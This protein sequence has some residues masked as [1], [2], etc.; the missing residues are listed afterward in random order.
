[1]LTKD[2]RQPVAKG[3]S[4]NDVTW[5]VR[6]GSGGR[7]VVCNGV[8]VLFEYRWIVASGDC[9]VVVERS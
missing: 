8:C 9:L 1:M 7:E 3:H 4:A 2:G 5:I 6:H